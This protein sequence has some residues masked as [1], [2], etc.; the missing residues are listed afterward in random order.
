VGKVTSLGFTS[1]HSTA[2]PSAS[3][4]QL[5][6]ILI[7]AGAVFFNHTTLPQSIMQCVNISL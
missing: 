3:N 7:D 5:A 6:Q 4:A 2:K 1:L